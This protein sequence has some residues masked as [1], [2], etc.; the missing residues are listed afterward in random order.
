MTEE[1]V[2]MRVRRLSK[3]Y[4]AVIGIIVL[5]AMLISAC[6]KKETKKDIKPETIDKMVNELL[7]QKPFEASMQK[8]NENTVMNAYQINDQNIEVVNAYLG[9]G[10]STEEIT[11]FKTTENKTMNKRIHD[12][13]ENRKES[14]AGYL[15][16]QAELL[17]HII[18]K[19]YKNYTV[20]CVAK[21][22]DKAESI[23]KKIA[24]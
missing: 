17:N 6:G 9:D 19:Q 13:V 23:I 12:Y 24:G 7:K 2:I 11:V 10:A 4:I 14:F 22:Y 15:P 16:E 8:V 1:Y 21:D 5:A 3:K 18:I 20:V